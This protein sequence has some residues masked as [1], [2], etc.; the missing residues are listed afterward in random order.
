MY[1]SDKEYQTESILFL[2][3]S[4]IASFMNGLRDRI[5]FPKIINRMGASDRANEIKARKVLAH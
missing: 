2:L 5:S 1:K 3:F 4:T